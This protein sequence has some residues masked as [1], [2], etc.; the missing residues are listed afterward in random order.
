MVDTETGGDDDS[1]RPNQLLAISLD[2]T[3]LDESRW[4]L[5]M[6]VV[7][8]RLL[9]P[10]GLRSLAPGSPA[11]KS[12]YYGDLRGARCSLPAGNG[13]GEADWS[14]HRCGL[15]LHPNQRSEARK[16]LL[17]FLAHLDEQCIGSIR[18]VFDAEPQYTPRGCITQ[19]WSVAEVARCWVKTASN[20]SK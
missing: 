14:L 9:T 4:Q 6:Q 19:A 13:L 3:V 5:V 20:D 11:Y 1:C 12:K 17:G 16:L 10:V 15:K 18:E 8:E 7:T 2:Y